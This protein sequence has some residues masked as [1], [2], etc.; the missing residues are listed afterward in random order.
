[1]YDGETTRG[2]IRKCAHQANSKYQPDYAGDLVYEL[3]TCLKQQ[4]PAFLIVSQRR[5]EIS[6]GY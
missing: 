2:I 4:S 5:D 1:M 6:R 3:Q